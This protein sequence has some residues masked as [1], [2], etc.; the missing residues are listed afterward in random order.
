M[1]PIILVGAGIL[2]FGLGLGLG[3]WFSH[4][5]EAA[6][7]GD[8]QQELDEY[9]RHVTEH[10]SETA[11]HFQALGQQYRS[12]YKHM[13]TGADALCDAAQVDGMLEFPTADTAALTAGTEEPEFV[14]EPIRDYAPE[15]ASAPVEV[16][17]AAEEPET[18]EPPVEVSATE[19]AAVEGTAEEELAD[20]ISKTAATETERTVH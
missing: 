12:L 14:Q 20:A 10:F 2:L 18:A 17:I 9:R 16:E 11:Q 6:K 5:R 4:R 1:S 15:E 3:Y 7:A 8:V 19:E 13:A